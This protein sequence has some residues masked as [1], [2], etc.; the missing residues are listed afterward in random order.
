MNK[1]EIIPKDSKIYFKLVNLFASLYV[2]F[3][4]GIQTLKKTLSYRNSL[5]IVPIIKKTSH[6]LLHL[7][8][9]FQILISSQK[10]LSQHLTH[11]IDAGNN[12]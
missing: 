6:L 1:C 7:I 5:K 10:I 9:H 12:T 8:G 3:Q 4:S 11:H 2:A